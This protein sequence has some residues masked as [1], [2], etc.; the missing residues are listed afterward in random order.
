[1]ATA[2]VNTFKGIGYIIIGNLYDNVRMPK[3]LTFYLLVVLAI[4]TA[5]VKIQL[6]YSIERNRPRGCCPK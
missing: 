4:L 2:A 3:R 5:L 6:S 1:V